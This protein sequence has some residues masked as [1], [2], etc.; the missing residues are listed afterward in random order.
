[1]VNIKLQLLAAVLLSNF[2]IKKLDIEQRILW[3]PISIKL[4]RLKRYVKLI[5]FYVILCV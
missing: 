5:Y 1:M 3:D 4:K 2:R